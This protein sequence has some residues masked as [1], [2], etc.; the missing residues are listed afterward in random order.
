MNV[1]TIKTFSLSTILLPEVDLE[2]FIVINYKFF[3]IYLMSLC[4]TKYVLVIGS[5]VSSNIEF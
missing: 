4:L 5:I 1:F 2:V 3:T